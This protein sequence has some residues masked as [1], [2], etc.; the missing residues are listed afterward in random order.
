M[1]GAHARQFCQI[2]KHNTFD[3]IEEP[4]P[5]PKKGITMLMKLTEGLRLSEAGIKVSEKLIQMSSEQHQ[6]DKKL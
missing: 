1:T 5:E 3:D 2:W 6:V 4:E